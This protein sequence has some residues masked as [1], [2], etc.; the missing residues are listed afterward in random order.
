MCQQHFTCVGALF[1]FL[2]KINPTVVEQHAANCG[3]W[4]ASTKKIPQKIPGH[5]SNKFLDCTFFYAA[6]HW[7]SIKNFP[8]PPKIIYLP[9]KRENG[10]RCKINSLHL[11]ANHF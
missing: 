9:K 8:A 11:Q 4:L 2:P 5:I 1:L 10:S 3:K 7:R 6:N